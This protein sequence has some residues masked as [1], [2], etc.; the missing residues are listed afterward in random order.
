MKKKPLI[1]KDPKE[2]AQLNQLNDQAVRE[3]ELGD[4]QKAINILI[5]IIK[6]HPSYALAYYN[7]G[8]LYLSLGN[9]EEALYYFQEVIKI[10]EF[11]A[12]SYFGIGLA[13]SQIGKIVEAISYY[14]K[15]YQL[16]SSLKKIPLPKNIFSKVNH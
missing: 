2:I 7:L 5:A 3:I 14:Q 4:Y 13:L 16:D 8:N 9:P 6:K 10:D 11:H 12:K 15:A 1:I